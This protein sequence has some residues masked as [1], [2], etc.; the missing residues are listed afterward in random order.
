[1][2]SLLVVEDCVAIAAILARHLTGAGY[3]VTIAHD[4]VAAGARCGA[5]GAE[6]APGRRGAA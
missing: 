3:D 4:G 2:P 1:M 6:R 5:R